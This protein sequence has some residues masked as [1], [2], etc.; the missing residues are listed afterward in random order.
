MKYTKQMLFSAVI[1]LLVSLGVYGFVQ[2]R[3]Q[4]MTREILLQTPPLQMQLETVGGA[5]QQALEG[6]PLNRQAFRDFEHLCNLLRGV[7]ADL[8]KRKL[9]R[10]PPGRAVDELLWIYEQGAGRWSGLDAA[11]R[12]RYI[13]Q[14]L[15]NVKVLQ[16]AAD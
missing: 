2:W 8:H 9:N 16:S 14:V 11:E 7:A 5:M 3:L 1:A 13:R 6:N 12:R 4:D 15:R 10:T